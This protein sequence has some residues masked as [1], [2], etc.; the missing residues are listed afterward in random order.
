LDEFYSKK[1]IECESEEEETRP[2]SRL[3]DGMSPARTISKGFLSK[4]QELT[5]STRPAEK[6]HRPIGIKSEEPAIVKQMSTWKHS[7]ENINEF[8]SEYALPE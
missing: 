2:D 3:S 8:Y 5:V 1:L 6:V 7:V 4:M